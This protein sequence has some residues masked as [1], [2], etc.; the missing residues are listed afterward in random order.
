MNSTGSSSRIDDLSSPL[1]SAALEG[2]TTLSPGTALYQASKFCEC[3]APFGPPAP[4]IVRIV[5]GIDA[6]EKYR[7]FAA[8]L[9]IWSIAIIAKS[10][11]M[12]STIGR[13][14]TAPL[15]TPSPTSTASL[16]GVS[17]TRSSP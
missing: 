15:P 2:M 1:A 14:P 10:K 4:H 13:R 9:T 17:R 16:I 6:P 3:W 7:N 12:I 5:S 11:N 8:W